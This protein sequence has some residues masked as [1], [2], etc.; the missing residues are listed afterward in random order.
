[1]KYKVLVMWVFML[2]VLMPAR[3]HATVYMV[4]VVDQNITKV[5]CFEGMVDVANQFDPSQYINLTNSFITDI[6][7]NL[8]PSMPILLNEKQMQELQKSLSET[9]TETS[10]PHDNFQIVSNEGK[11]ANQSDRRAMMGFS[12]AACRAG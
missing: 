8:N 3:S 5:V 2:L 1:M 4:W 10:I 9:T 12:L 7:N 6:I 11:D